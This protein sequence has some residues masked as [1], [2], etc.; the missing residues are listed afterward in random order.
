MAQPAVPA[1]EFI[2]LWREASVAEVA[3]RIGVLP[4]S[5]RQRAS[6]MR[7]HG[8]DLPRKIGRRPPRPR[9]PTRQEKF[10]EAYLESK[11]LLEV[12]RKVGISLQGVRNRATRARNQGYGLESLPTV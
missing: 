9:G 2:R 5:A 12:A 6:N 7:R 10:I 4:A 1:D 3:Q 11:S 8:I